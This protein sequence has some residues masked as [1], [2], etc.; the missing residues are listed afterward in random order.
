V[1]TWREGMAVT[2]SLPRRP[3]GA[4]RLRVARRALAVLLVLHGLGHLAGT[5]DVLGRSL[6][7]RAA[8]LLGGAWAV[9]DPAVLGVLGALWALAAFAFTVTAV[10]TWQGRPAWPRALAV[11][12]EGSIVL[13]AV[14]LPSSA[15][16][17]AIDVALIGV[18]WEAQ[19]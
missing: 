19:R 12:A 16:G 1:A 4:A 6:D 17:L 14:G 10:L 15:I 18:A 7:G 9:G 8:E 11:A 5:S 13:L 3:L 2:S